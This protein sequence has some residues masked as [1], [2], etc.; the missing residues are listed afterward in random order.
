[1]ERNTAR[2]TVV[3]ITV[4]NDAI[5]ISDEEGRYE[6]LKKADMTGGDAE[7]WLSRAHESNRID[8]T[9]KSTSVVLE[10]LRHRP[11]LTKL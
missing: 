3:S 10:S 11:V 7:H 1:M 2:T 9:G 4:A 6:L 8:G 5:I